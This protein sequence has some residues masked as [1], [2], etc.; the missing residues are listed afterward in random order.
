MTH[1]FHR[2]ARAVLVAAVALSALTACAQEPAPEPQLQQYM[3]YSAARRAVLDAGW[4]PPAMAPRGRSTGDW[5]REFA[6]INQ[7]GY[8]EL[9][10]CSGTGLARCAFEFTD[11]VGQRLVVLTAGEGG[12]PPVVE[13]V[14]EKPTYS[15][16]AEQREAL[17]VL[18]ARN[19]VLQPLDESLFGMSSQGEPNPTALANVRATLSAPDHYPYAA[20]GDF[21]AD[22]QVDFALM[23]EDATPRYD[24]LGPGYATHVVVIFNGTTG[25]YVVGGFDRREQGRNVLFYPSPDG[26]LMVAGWESDEC[27]AFMP[28]GEGYRVDG[29]SG[30]YD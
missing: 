2:L 1:T 4:R 5:H 27:Y 13:W 12:D 24:N 17:D 10:A 29:C 8:T 21:N 14:I 15:L 9:V 22:G 11:S 25:G 30:G 18:L 20:T 26:R 19:P 6:F 16:D 7:T 28:S 3:V 23:L